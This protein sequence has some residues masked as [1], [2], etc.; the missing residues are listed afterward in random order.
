PAGEAWVPLGD[1]PSWGWYDHRLHERELAVPADATGP[2]ELDTW[3]VPLRVGG[4]R[5]VTVA[6]RTLGGPPL[7]YV[8]PRLAVDREPADGLSVTL[9]PGAVP[10][11]L[12][13]VE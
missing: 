13:Q 3:A 11:L 12:V 6:G 5:E 1:D 4:D 10:G 8:A 9:L 2:V 7:G